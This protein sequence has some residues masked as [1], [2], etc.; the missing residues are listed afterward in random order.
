MKILA[1]RL[2]DPSVESCSCHSSLTLY[3]DVVLLLLQQTE[4]ESSK[5]ISGG[6]ANA[7]EAANA[8]QTI[9]ELRLQLLHATDHAEAATANLKAAEDKVTEEMKSIE[10]KH[11]GQ[12]MQ[13]SL[14]ATAATEALQEDLSKSARVS[15]R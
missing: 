8:R 6:F 5:A 10:E 13:Q 14:Q 1:S 2:V 12:L 9:E 15:N 4:L 3:S 7:E 11:I